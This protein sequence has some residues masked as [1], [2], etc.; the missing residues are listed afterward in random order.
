[1]YYTQNPEDRFGVAR[2][3]PGLWT[4][5]R[6]LHKGQYPALVQNEKMVL[7][8]DTNEDF[9]FDWDSD[10]LQVG[11]F[12]INNHAGGGMSVGKWSAGCQVVKGDIAG[13][14]S[15]SWESGPWTTYYKRA[16]MAVNSVYK[17]VLVPYNWIDKIYNSN[18]QFA[19][20]GSAG[21]LVSAIQG[22]LGANVDGGYGEFTM[23]EVMKFQR[24]NNIQA[25]GI[26]GP[27]T[28][29]AMGLV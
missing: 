18:A 29:G 24:A 10:Y 7:L 3:V 1:M 5:K 17:Y 19:L 2:L 15:R 22:K 25:N 20:Y 21:N 13:G 14:A 12:G 27:Q 11:F 4:F 26:C 28:L 8:R 23:R 9:N 6:G 16:T